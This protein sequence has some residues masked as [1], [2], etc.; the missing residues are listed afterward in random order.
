MQKHTGKLL[1]KGFG[2][3]GVSNNL[4]TK[5]A[6]EWKHAM[7]KFIRTT[8]MELT[9]DNKKRGNTVGKVENVNKRRGTNKYEETLT[10]NCLEELCA[11]PT[12]EMPTSYRGGPEEK[13][14]AATYTKHVA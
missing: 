7:S 10:R 12:D 14:V 2:H 5:A 1:S 11:A 3:I 6:G 9:E 4:C 8:G 13:S